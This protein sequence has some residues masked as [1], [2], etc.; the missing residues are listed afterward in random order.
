M[1]VT[2]EGIETPHQAEVLSQLSADHFQGYLYGRPA[3]ATELAAYL[4]RSRAL[5]SKSEPAPAN[6]AVI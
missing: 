2:A 1:T 4:L 5:G 3:P 6:R